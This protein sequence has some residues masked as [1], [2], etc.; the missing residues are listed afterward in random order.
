[1][2]DQHKQAQASLPKLCAI[3]HFRHFQG[4]AQFAALALWALWAMLVFNWPAILCPQ[5][6]S[7]SDSS[8]LCF[9]CRGWAHDKMMKLITHINGSAPF[10]VS[11]YMKGLQCLIY[12]RTLNPVLCKWATESESLQSN[13]RHKH[14]RNPP[15]PTP[16]CCEGLLY[17]DS[18]TLAKA[19][20]VSKQWLF[21]V[22]FVSFIV[23]QKVKIIALQV[24]KDNRKKQESWL[25]LCIK[26]YICHYLT[27]GEYRKNLAEH[28][29][30]ANK[31][32]GAV[33]HQG[34]VSRLADG[35]VY[36]SCSSS[37]PNFC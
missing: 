28:E 18:P 21:Q 14:A 30:W 26:Y 24:C 34:V 36:H 37:L 16:H 7:T 33:P 10:T 35:S 13:L 12:N 31:S 1:M 9:S 22:Y 5:S 8:C 11:V 32:S 27:I 25:L 15:P 17:Y 20:T 29:N 3:L 6:P 2:W 23:N 4:L 19:L